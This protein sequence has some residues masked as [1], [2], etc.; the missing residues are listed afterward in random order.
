MT[1]LNPQQLEAV[2]HVNGPLLILAG[3][4]SGK[5]RVITQRIAH[6]IQHCGVRPGQ[7]MAVTFTNKAAEE[8]K[9]RV[10]GLLGGRAQEVWIATFHSACVRI[11]RS[12]N[13]GFVIYDDDD[14]M[15]LVKECLEEMKVDEKLLSPRAVLSRISAAKNELLS[16]EDYVKK[17]GD[18]DFFTPRVAEVYKLYQKKLSENN[19]MDFGDLIFK[20]VQ[21]FRNSPMDL[22][23]YQERFRYILIDEYQDTNHA[24]YVLSRLLTDSHKNLCV[25]GDDDQ[26]VYKWRG[27]DIKNILSFEAD[28][29][30]CKVVRL[31]QN[32][33]ST[34]TVL[35]IANQV[36]ENNEGRKGK[37]LWSDHG[38]GEK[39]TLYEAF[40]EKDEARF[41]VDEIVKQAAAGRRYNDMAIFYRTNAQS[42]TFEDEL[43]RQ[44]IPY[45]IFGGTKFYERKEIKDIIAYLRVLV[46]PQDSL[47]LKRIINVPPRGLGK[48]AIEALE[49]FASVQSISLY[50]S[51][52]R[53]S[54]ISELPTMSRSR[55]ASFLVLVEGFRREI[56][57][58]LKLSLLVEKIIQ[59]SGYAEMLEREKTVESEG[60]LEN[61]TELLTVAEEFEKSVEG[62]D[63]SLFLDQVALVGQTDTY[64]PEKGILPM[65]TLHLAKGLEFPVVFLVGMEEGLFPHSRSQDEPEEVEEERRLCYVG[66]TR[67]REKIYLTR[68][69]KRRLYGGEQFNPASRFLDEMPANLV[70]VVRPHRRSFDADPES[71]WNDF[72]QRPEEEIG[73]RSGTAVRHPTFGAGV[74]K[75]REGTGDGEKVT[76]Y[77]NNGLVKVLMVKFANLSV[78]G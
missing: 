60:R 24:Q 44:K 34:K 50:E 42:R 56:E 61:L 71:T 62:S 39:A 6:L 58:R 72:D 29:P 74:V 4:G 35:A 45:T 57:D 49:S 53:T 2:H 9:S 30:G 69:E 31:E 38:E 41:V 37:N 46:N 73:L 1:L 48:K 8:M 27:A 10:T 22:K 20:V 15:T 7:I 78:V 70:D 12:K 65:M 59:E 64:D 11:L 47:N 55:L 75:R 26:C 66:L 36:I 33:R 54:E 16:P 14:S 51:L 21:L 68:A 25:V 40:D 5:T 28:N 52:K 77:F 32:Y 76:V 3:A 18:F 67:A 23:A 43:R 19:A 17:A 13:A 63:P